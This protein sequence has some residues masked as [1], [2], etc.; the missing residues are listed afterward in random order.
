MWGYCWGACSAVLYSLDVSRLR[1]CAHTCVQPTLPCA[2][3][4]CIGPD[5]SPCT[6]F[7]SFVL[8]HEELL[9]RLLRPLLGLLQRYSC[10]WLQT[11]AADASSGSAAPAVPPGV[12]ALSNADLGAAGLPELARLLKGYNKSPVPAELLLTPEPA[13]SADKLALRR[14]HALAL[15][16]CA[17]PRCAN[18]AGG[19]R[20]GAARAAL[21]RLQ[22]GSPL[23]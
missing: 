9:Q 17:N 2:S 21:R 4:T 1:P 5:P 18:L 19:Q 23:L 13:A 20:V 3:V 22:S 7:P 10:T 16:S 6:L 14:A 15:R 12:V 8:Q 11:A